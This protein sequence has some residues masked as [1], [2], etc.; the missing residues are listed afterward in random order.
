M[1]STGPAQ[2]QQ[3]ALVSLAKRGS[4]LLLAAQHNFSTASAQHQHLMSAQDGT[5][6]LN[7]IQQARR[8]A[9]RG[10]EQT[11]LGN[12]STR[13][14]NFATAIFLCRLSN[15]ARKRQFEVAE[16]DHHNTATEHFEQKSMG[17]DDKTST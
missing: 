14:A 12:V 2:V 9:S 5:K 11:S 3:Y 4:W 10:I 8:T 15:L 17:A 7:A 6:T 13:G 1:I 16:E